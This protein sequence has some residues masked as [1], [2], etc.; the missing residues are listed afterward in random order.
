VYRL[1]LLL[2]V[3]CLS[4]SIYADVYQY[5]DE[6]GNILY[7]DKP[8]KGGKRIVESKPS[9]ASP[10]ARQL[11]K[12]PAVSD[13]KKK[14][15]LPI[16]SSSQK[17]DQKPEKAL[18]YE[19]VKITSPEDDQAY[20]SNSGDVL[21]K[22]SLSPILQKKFGHHLKIKFDGVLLSEKWQTDSI[23]LTNLD[24]GTHSVSL[25]VVDKTGKQ[26]K[27]SQKTTFHLLRYS[28]LFG[29]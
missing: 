24:R 6:E 18:P 13:I 26:L 2:F 16:S 14:S 7:S 21:I 27:E 23:Q 4:P 3:F 29:H 25:I 20:R 11:P 22:V 28:R 1:T 12:T 17:S 15:D 5:K 9:V 19:Y 8:V 10:P